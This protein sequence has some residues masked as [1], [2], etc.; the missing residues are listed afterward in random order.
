MNY[1]VVNALLYTVT[2]FL[3]R[4]KRK[5]I[6]E[7]FVLLGLYTFVAIIG[8]VLLYYTEDENYWELTMWPY[9]YLYIVFHLRGFVVWPLL[10]HSFENNEIIKIK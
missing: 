4:R 10:I 8:V 9:I 7:G 2:L 1:V 5:E 3:H 6:D